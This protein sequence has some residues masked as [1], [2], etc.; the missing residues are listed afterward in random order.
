MKKYVKK[1]I[2]D[3]D[4]ITCDVCNQSCKKHHNIESAT[5]SAY[6]GYDSKRDGE[7]FDVDICESCFDKLIKFMSDLKGSSIN[8]ASTENI[9]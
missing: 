2:D 6:W 5:L 9:I 7:T 1:T 3:L 4:D 8:P